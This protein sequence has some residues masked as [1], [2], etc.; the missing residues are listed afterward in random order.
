MFSPL[1]F[2]KPAKRINMKKQKSIIYVDLNDPNLKKKVEIKCINEGITLK[3]FVTRS[4]LK[5][6]KKGK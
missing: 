4:L 2:H 3:E 1:C 5:N 6:L